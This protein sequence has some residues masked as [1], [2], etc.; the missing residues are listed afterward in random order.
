MDIVSQNPVT[1]LPE[2][3]YQVTRLFFGGQDLAADATIIG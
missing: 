1:G 2:G 3:F